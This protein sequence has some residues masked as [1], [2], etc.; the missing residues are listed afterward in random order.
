[1]K[2]VHGGDIYRYE[3]YLDFSANCNPLGTP[4]SVRKAI[5]DAIPAIEHYPDVRC[6]KLK[7]ALASHESVSEDMIFCGNGAAEV[8]FSL[9]LAV[10]PQKALLLAPTFA[11][12]EQ[13]LD[14]VDC[15]I[16]YHE[17]KE[18]QGF[19]A[20]ETIIEVLQRERP[21]IFF[22]C[23][24]NNP[25]G[26]LTE[27]ILL[28]S[29]LEICK[30]ENI[31]LA[32]DECFLD[33]VRN[34]EDYTLKSYLKD[35]GN[36]FIFKAF[37]KRYAMA[38]V[39]LGYG[40]S[41]SKR[42]LDRM[43]EVTQPWNVSGLAQAAGIAALKET[44]YVK[45]GRELI[46]TEQEYLKS[47]LED[48]GCRVYGSRANYIFFRGRESLWEEMAQRKILIRDCSNYRGLE[49]GFFRIA[50]RTHEENKK[51][52]EALR[53]STCNKENDKWQKQL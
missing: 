35:Y 36:L 23:N 5:A 33:F 39:R 32:L 7:E 52:A 42:L 25:T 51:F 53:E 6:E 9:C 17:L 34:P 29:L 46:F 22:L 44:E 27:R 30:K 12:Y 2:H 11:E 45:R 28:K 37:T 8:I 50:V 21:D 41:G 48:F 18:T 19:A 15:E 38:G 20:D 43:C 10:K 26:V 49:K 16:V 13:A 14:A 40:L 1:M 4:Q 47:A 24:P 3:N 31:I